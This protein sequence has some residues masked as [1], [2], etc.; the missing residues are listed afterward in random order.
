MKMSL[1]CFDFDLNL[2][3]DLDSIM[4]PTQALAVQGHKNRLLALKDDIFS[5]IAV[6]DHAEYLVKFN[7]LLN[8]IMSNPSFK[9]VTK[10]ITKDVSKSVS[11]MTKKWGWGKS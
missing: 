2:D 6:E 11:G 3:L 1:M 5:Q 4:V 9:Q 8:A 10:D 7:E